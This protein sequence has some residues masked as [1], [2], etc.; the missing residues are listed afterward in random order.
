M[1]DC[2]HVV[3]GGCELLLE[4]CENAGFEKVLVAHVA[5]VELHIMRIFR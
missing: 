5:F 1:I 3:E 4:G 2:V